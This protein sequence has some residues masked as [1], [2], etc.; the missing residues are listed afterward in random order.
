M[1]RVSHA[2]TQIKL[3]KKINHRHMGDKKTTYQKDRLLQNDILVRDIFS[4]LY[5]I[6]LPASQL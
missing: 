6:Y 2:V 3:Q 4:K 5:N 1:R